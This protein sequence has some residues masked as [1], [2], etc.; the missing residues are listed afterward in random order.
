MPIAKGVLYRCVQCGL[1]FAPG[2][3][4]SKYCSPKCAKK[5]QEKGAWPSDDA[6]AF[7]LWQ[8]PASTLCRR[9]GISDRAIKKRCDNR[10]IEKPGRGYW[11]RRHV[12]KLTRE[13]EQ[14]LI[15]MG[16]AK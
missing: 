12:G 5:G 6:L 4:Q 3:R 9:L 15:H 14:R 16:I 2:K 1:E 7:L 8:L 11:A 10:G 13:E